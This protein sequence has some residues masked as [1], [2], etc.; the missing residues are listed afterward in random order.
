MNL[1]ETRRILR[2]PYLG[3]VNGKKR[4]LRYGT[5][6]LAILGILWIAVRIGD[7]I[8]GWTLYSWIFQGIKNIGVLPDPITGAIAVWIVAVIILFGPTMILYFFA[9][10]SKRRMAVLTVA[11]AISL[12][13]VLLYTIGAMQPKGNLFNPL[14]GTPN[15]NY[16]KYPDGTIKLFDRGYSFDPETGIKLSP[17]DAKTAS[18]YRSQEAL[19]YQRKMEERNREIQANEEQDRKAAEANSQKVRKESERRELIPE[20][21]SP[22]VSEQK[23]QPK[24]NALLTREQ[25]PEVLPQ[26]PKAQPPAVARKPIGYYVPAEPVDRYVTAEAGN[27]VFSMEKRNA[28][29]REGEE[30]HCVGMVTNKSDNPASFAVQYPPDAKNEFGGAYSPIDPIN[31]MGPVQTSQGTLRF[32]GAHCLQRLDPNASEMFEVDIYGVTQYI[33][34]LDLIF[35]LDTGDSVN[36]WPIPIPGK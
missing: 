6:L 21:K 10:K 28:C 26:I 15:Y 8:M 12:W 4:I 32:D 3:F 9:G 23:P 19:A 7:I 20:E 14:I 33:G 22:G 16:A 13:M 29:N 17:L 2:G 18:E 35:Q 31:C 30:V 5:I 36:L 1:N 11:S 34:K 27:L 25:P 24:E